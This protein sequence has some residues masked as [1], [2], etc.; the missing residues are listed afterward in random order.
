MHWSLDYENYL[1]TKEKTK[2]NID[3]IIFKDIYKYNNM[4]DKLKD[5]FDTLAAEDKRIIV[6]YGKLDSILCDFL[7]S[8]NES[9]PISVIL[10]SP[11]YFEEIY[12]ISYFYNLT[13]DNKEYYNDAVATEVSDIYVGGSLGFSMEHMRKPHEKN[14]RVTPCLPQTNGLFPKHNSFFIRPEDINLYEDY[15]DTIDFAFVDNGAI[16][17]D[18]YI[19]NKKWIGDLSEIIRGLPQGL[20][21]EGIIPDFGMRRLS[22]EQRCQNRGNRCN[23]CERYAELSQNAKKNGIYFK[24]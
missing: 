12:P 2:E 11:K 18:V 24:A 17:A 22:C 23:I 20:Y 5:I 9:Y 4:L 1:K 19:S 15:I 21:G 7:K 8:Y 10:E 3:E 6:M 14:V 13:V 16:L